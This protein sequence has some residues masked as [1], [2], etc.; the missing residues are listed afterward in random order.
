[1]SVLIELIDVTI[2]KKGKKKSMKN[3]LIESIQ[4]EIDRR[5]LEI[6]S[7]EF[8]REAIN[9]KTLE[10]GQKIIV[11]KLLNLIDEDDDV[12]NVYHDMS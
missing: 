4:K 7:S 3:R 5:G 2:P 10:E 9:V 1:M 11:D 6:V 8:E 12:Q